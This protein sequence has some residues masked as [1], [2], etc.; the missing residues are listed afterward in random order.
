M[1]VRGLNAS[2]KLP[3]YIVIVLDGDLIGFLNYTQYGFFS[4][5]GKWIEWLAK[6]IHTAVED[7]RKLLPQKTLRQGEPFIYWISAPFHDFF[8]SE[9]N[10]ARGKFNACLDSVLKLYDNMRV[11]KLKEYWNTKNRNLVGNLNRQISAEG[12][13]HYWRSIDAAIEFNV[14]KRE[15]YLSRVKG[16]RNNAPMAKLSSA[17]EC[18]DM[19]RFFHRHRH[20]QFH[21][22]KPREQCYMLPRPK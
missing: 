2:K 20:D 16:M 11:M 8:G 3:K 17:K 22:H 4:M 1:V 13:A 18:N 21:W 19:K 12:L 14:N 7:R 10:A 5:M 15:E 9:L 6:E